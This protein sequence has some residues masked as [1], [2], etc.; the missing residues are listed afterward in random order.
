MVLPLF[1]FSAGISLLPQ[2][3]ASLPFAKNMVPLGEKKFLKHWPSAA[4]HSWLLIHRDWCEALWK[5]DYWTMWNA[6]DQRK[7]RKA[8]DWNSPV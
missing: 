7:R 6:P 8:N 1:T 5:C 4:A 2:N 3:C